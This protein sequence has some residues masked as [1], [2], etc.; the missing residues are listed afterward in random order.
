M[1]APVEVT[2]PPGVVSTTSCRPTVPEG[3]VRLTDVALIT[4][5]EVAALPPKVTEL[6]PVKFVPVIVKDVPP[7]TGPDTI[8]RLVIVGGLALVVKF[9]TFPYVVPVVFDAQ[10]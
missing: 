2:E 1:K 6:V 9:A 10:P 7:A 3:F 8:E 5:T 4:K